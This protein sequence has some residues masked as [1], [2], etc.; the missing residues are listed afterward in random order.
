MFQL[1]LCQSPALLSSSRHLLGVKYF[2]ALNAND[3]VLMLCLVCE[4]F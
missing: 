1:N 2:G 4:G 3:I